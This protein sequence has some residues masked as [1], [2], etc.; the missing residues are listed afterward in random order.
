[1]ADS[2]PLEIVTTP[3]ETHATVT[4]AVNAIAQELPDPEPEKASATG[5]SADVQLCSAIHEGPEMVRT[6]EEEVAA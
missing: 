6:P 4:D 2:A 3:E 1:M 5:A